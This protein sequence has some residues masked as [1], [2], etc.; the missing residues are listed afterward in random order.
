M[1]NTQKNNIPDFY[2]GDTK[3]NKFKIDYRVSFYYKNSFID[4]SN[5]EVG[6]AATTIKVKND[7]FKLILEAKI[8]FKN[9]I[10]KFNF[11]NPTDIKIQS[12]QLCGL[13]GDCLRST[14]MK[15]KNI[16]VYRV[17]DRLRIPLNRN[18]SQKTEELFSSLLYYKGQIETTVDTIKKYI[19]ENNDRR[20]SFERAL[21]GKKREIITY[22]EWV[23]WSN[24]NLMSEN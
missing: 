19:N 17:N 22:E 21:G 3:M 14:M 7:H 8:I 18:D 9:I 20:L 13:K 5:I 23:D 11:I 16:V 10:T 15:P 12:I 24:E 2:S 6:R 4:V 1:L